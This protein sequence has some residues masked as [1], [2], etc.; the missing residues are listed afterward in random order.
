M[1]SEVPEA[2]WPRVWT[3]LTIVGSS[4]VLFVLALVAFAILYALV[5]EELII[6]GSGTT[7]GQ[8]PLDTASVGS[9][10]LDYIRV[11]LLT[12][13]AA[14]VS[15]LGLA[16]CFFLDSLM[17][18]WLCRTAGGGRGRTGEFRPDFKVHCYLLSL[19]V[20]PVTVVS[21]AVSLVPLAGACVSFVLSIYGIF[22]Q[23]YALRASMQ[24][25]RSNART[26]LVLAFVLTFVLVVALIVVLAVLSAL[27]SRLF[28]AQ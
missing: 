6:D 23:Y 28:G 4:V 9:A 17:L 5:T 10:A 19:V 7:A 18:Y 12:L 24:L 16:A 20:V 26:V 1:A 13:V 15:T 21:T 14:A 27:S 22:L 2:S 11:L 8:G 25:T 3:G